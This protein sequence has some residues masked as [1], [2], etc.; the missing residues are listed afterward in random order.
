MPGCTPSPDADY[1]VSEKTGKAFG[2]DHSYS[3]ST[4]NSSIALQGLAET[5]KFSVTRGVTVSPSPLRGDSKVQYESTTPPKGKGRSGLVGRANL[6]G[7]GDSN[8]SPTPTIV[9]ESDAS[10]MG[11]EATNGQERTGGLWSV[12]EATHHI[13]TW[14]YW[15][16]SWLSKPLQRT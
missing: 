8:N 15:Q 16:S 5:D 11:W 2:E 12:H 13:I 3:E 10:N 9:L 4:P 6:G 7:N 1:S 14:K